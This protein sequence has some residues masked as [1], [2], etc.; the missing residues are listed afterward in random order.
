MRKTRKMM[1]EN[2]KFPVWNQNAAA[3]RIKGPG[4]A[5]VLSL[6]FVLSLISGFDGI[7]AQ[8]RLADYY[9]QIHLFFQ[10]GKKASDDHLHDRRDFS[11][12]GVS[13][14]RYCQC[15][16]L[17]TDNQNPVLQ[18]LR[19]CSGGFRRLAGDSRGKLFATGDQW[20]RFRVHLRI[21]FEK[22]RRNGQR[23]VLL[24][25]RRRRTRRYKYHALSGRRRIIFT[26]LL[27]FNTVEYFQTP[28]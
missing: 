23:R 28:E 10:K 6:A 13:L 25:F 22:L 17:R 18:F 8:Q 20:R 26:E 9:I 7:G 15:V 11:G 2:K 27:F 12:A 24:D 14:R 16:F 5:R 19:R 3:Y 4:L 1:T 21:R